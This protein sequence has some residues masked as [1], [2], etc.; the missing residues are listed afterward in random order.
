MSAPANILDLVQKLLRLAD[1][2]RGATEHEAESALAKAEELMT[3]HKIDSAMLRMSHGSEDLP[4]IAVQK[5]VINL[6]KT[7]N[8]ADMLILS[9]LQNHFNVR[10]VLFKNA[11]ATPVDIIGTWEDVQFAIH[12][13][14]FLRETFSRC[15]NEFKV[16]ASTPD[17][18]SFYRGLH[19]GLK[20]AILEGKKRAEA[21]ASTEERSRYQIVLV[22]TAAAIDRYMGERYGQLRKRRSRSSRVYSESYQAGKAK[23]GKIEIKRAL[24]GNAA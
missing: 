8:P 15:W 17:R 23:G 16:S 1:T 6:P 22:D 9:L 21:A 11:H 13:F 4:G 20:S 2:S 10:I 14:H 12:V 7:I 24:P 5:E 3:R 18:K 19:D